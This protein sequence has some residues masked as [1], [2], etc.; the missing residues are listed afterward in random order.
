MVVK[1]SGIYLQDGWDVTVARNPGDIE[2][3]RPVW[4]QMQAKEPYPVLNAD[5]QWQEDLFYIFAPRPYP[6]FINMVRTSTMGL[7]TSLE[8]I[9]NRLG[10]TGWIKRRWRDLLR[11]RNV[12]KK[13][14]VGR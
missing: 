8:H 4:E 7:N 12:E 6:I 13:H 3:L 11:I 10:L 2:A 14:R 5:E 1:S 9:V